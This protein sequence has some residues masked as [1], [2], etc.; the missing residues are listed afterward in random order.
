MGISV[1]SNLNLPNAMAPIAI[2]A[3]LDTVARAEPQLVELLL[4]VIREVS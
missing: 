1:L 3:I 4:G 2:E